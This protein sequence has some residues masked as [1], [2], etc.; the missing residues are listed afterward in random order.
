MKKDKMGFRKEKVDLAKVFEEH[1][2]SENKY[3]EKKLIASLITQIIGEI[4]DMSK[5]AQLS[6]EEKEVLCKYQESIVKLREQQPKSKWEQLTSF[7][8]GNDTVDESWEDV[9]KMT[10]VM[11]RQEKLATEMIDQCGEVL[12][13]LLRVFSDLME[14]GNLHDSEK[15]RGFIESVSEEDVIDVQV[16]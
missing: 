8:F 4:K 6:S 13:S 9:E 5:S 2:K 11:Q 15:T 12:E 1:L 14:E 3:P 10:E 16:D 7:S